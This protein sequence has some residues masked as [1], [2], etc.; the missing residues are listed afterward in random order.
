MLVLC[1][2]VLNVLDFSFTIA[3]GSPDCELNPFIRI[4]WDLLGPHA[5]MFVKV[6]MTTGLITFLGSQ[7]T[8]S[9]LARIG[10]KV[11]V[12]V[13]ALLIIYHLL[14]VHYVIRN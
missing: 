14:G 2:I 10:I 3:L 11:L 7:C 12:I 9:E 1:L 4:T 6:L 8:R 13:Y 5:F